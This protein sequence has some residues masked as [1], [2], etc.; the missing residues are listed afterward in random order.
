MPKSKSDISNNAIRIFLHQVGN[1]YDRIRGYEEYRSTSKQKKE[2][3]TFF[4]NSCCYCG[5][6]L[7]DTSLTEDHLIPTN[8]EALGLH[9][10]GNVVPCCGSC[11]KKK[12]SKKWETFLQTVCNDNEYQQREDR[13]AA[14]QCQYDYEPNLELGSIA[15]NLYQDVGAV[16]M[17]LI[18]LRFKQAEEIITRIH[19]KNVARA[20]Y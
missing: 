19:I 17:T 8:K 3:L 2:I 14:F 20:V 12:H 11:N 7:T 1:F 9:A 10:W 5:I 4:S 13:I 16:A 6:P 15:N 18:D